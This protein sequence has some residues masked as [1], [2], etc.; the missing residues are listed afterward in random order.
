MGEIKNRNYF[1]G[2]G[3]ERE[4]INYFEGKGKERD[5]NFFIQKNIIMGN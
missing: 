5:K 3:R 4:N 1:E 2:K